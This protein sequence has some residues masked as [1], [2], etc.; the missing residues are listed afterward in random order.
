MKYFINSKTGDL[1]RGNFNYSPTTPWVE[2][3]Q[4]QYVCLL[5]ERVAM[6]VELNPEYIPVNFIERLPNIGWTHHR[7]FEHTI[8]AEIQKVTF[9]GDWLRSQSEL[10]PM[11]IPVIYVYE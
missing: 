9:I 3:E 8:E 6:K 1:F 11:L 10:E 5:E 2:I 7:Y 4:D